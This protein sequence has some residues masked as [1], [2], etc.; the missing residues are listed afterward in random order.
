MQRSTFILLVAVVAATFAGA[1]AQTGGG[2]QACLLG[3]HG[4]LSA[5]SKVDQIQELNPSTFCRMC[6]PTSPRV[7]GSPHLCVFGLKITASVV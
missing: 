4:T 7:N 3:S 1:A 5:C 6:S 2:G